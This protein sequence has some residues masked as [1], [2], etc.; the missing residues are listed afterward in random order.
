MQ[1]R[2]R[3]M[4]ALTQGYAHALQRVCCLGRRAGDHLVHK[5]RLAS[6]KAKYRHLANVSTTTRLVGNE[7]RGWTYSPME[8]P[9]QAMV[10]HL[11]D[12]ELLP[13]YP[14]GVMF[15]LVITAEAHPAFP[16]AC[17]HTNTTTELS[18]IVEALH[19]LLP[20]GPVPRDSR[21]LHLL[22]LSACS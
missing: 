16:R 22:W 19:F 13:A 10:S 3:S 21:G 6:S 15:G 7:F 5:V 14:R 17:Q 1:R 8:E 12:G 4:T 9:I 11:Q 18:G 20:L 2:I